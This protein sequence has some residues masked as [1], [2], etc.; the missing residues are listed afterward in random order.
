M[1]EHK[2]PIK[3]A[4]LVGSSWVVTIDP[5]I[6]KKHAITEETFFSQELIE[7]GILLKVRR[8]SEDVEAKKSET[9]SA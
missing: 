2:H 4:H 3:K 1:T 5:T 7:N 9:R 6:A 8:L